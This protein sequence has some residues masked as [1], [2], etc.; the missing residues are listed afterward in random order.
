MIINN[1]LA[2]LKT[3]AVIS[4]IAVISF[5]N[6]S[7]GSKQSRTTD[8]LAIANEMEA[9]LTKGMMDIWYPLCIDKEYGGYLSNFDKAWKQRETQPKFIVTQAR[10]IWATAQMAKMYP[11][12]KL[13][14]EF[15]EHGYKFL[16]DVMWDK[17]YG[18]YFTMTN[19]EGKVSGDDR[20]EMTKIAYGNA[21][22]IYGLAAYFE[23]S[24]DSFALDLAIRSFDW[25]DEHSYD[26]QFGGYFQFMQRDGTPLIEGQDGTPP[27]DQN[28]SIHLIEGFTELYK[29][30]KDDH[31]KSRI[32]ELLV[33]IRDTITTGKGHMNL[34][35]RQD[36]SPVYYTD[37]TYRGG[38]SEHLFDH[39]SFG[40]DIE[41]AYL[42][43]EASEVIGIVNDTKTYRI[44]KKMADHTI[45]NGWDHELGATFDAGYYFG[46][47]DEITILNKH[48]QW[49]VSTES[50]HT[51]LIMS[52]LYPDDSLDYY[53]K[54]TI[55]WDFCKN[56]LIDGENGGWY[57][58]GL[59]EVP[60]AANEDKGG[61][62]KG[63][64]HSVRSLINCI[65]I[66]RNIESDH[67]NGSRQMNQ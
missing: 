57:R 29:V 49:W 20:Y 6:S 30:W 36:W 47:Q 19:R 4:I 32:N 51:M 26:P 58:V 13:Y 64:Y 52:E 45:I 39:I 33:I 67:H 54:F 10:H 2:M 62:W 46:D 35:F 53:N 23:I 40:H 18:G 44:S 63:N 25:L 11:E 5:S 37:E 9:V 34:F 3:S 56:Y 14:R 7:C 43:L 42:L 1:K 38:E 12:N 48:T 21:F 27:K 8:R 60:G 16:R 55:T 31:L 61:I 41:T 15:S 66:L 50:F 59:N 17:E 28:S 24:N 22:A 65:N